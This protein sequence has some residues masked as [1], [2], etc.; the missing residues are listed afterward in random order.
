LQDFAQT[1]GDTLSAHSGDVESGE[2]T[3]LFIIEDVWGKKTRS[4]FV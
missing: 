1:F 3:H 2:W 4:L